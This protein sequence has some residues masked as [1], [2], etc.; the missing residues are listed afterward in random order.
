MPISY[1][2]NTTYNYL[3]VVCRGLITDR[4]VLEARLDCLSGADWVPGMPELVDLSKADFSK[5]TPAG[6]EQIAGIV[7]RIY[8]ANGLTRVKVGVYT[9][10]LLP[11]VITEL[12]RDYSRD[13]VEQIRV[14]DERSAARLWLVGRSAPEEPLP[15]P[16]LPA[17]IMQIG[18][19]AR[20]SALKRN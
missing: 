7:D 16:R 20:F 12:Y 2:I 9:R 8:R 17:K 19:I 5:V 18:Q 13:L 3:E 4:E 11:S 10:D 14:F 6:I 15:M 1:L